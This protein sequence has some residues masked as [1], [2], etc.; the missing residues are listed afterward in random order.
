MA[1]KKK[2]YT[3]YKKEPPK[4]IEIR[5]MIKETKDEFET[6]REKRYVLVDADTGKVFDDAQGYGYKSKQSAMAKYSYASKSKE[7][8]HKIAK[9][10]ALV[11][12]FWRTHKGFGDYVSELA[13]DN[14]KCGQKFTAKDLE[15]AMSVYGISVP[16]GLSCAKLIKYW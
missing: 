9:E 3:G 16:D 15:E 8:L 13:L 7:E 10:K 4:N 1:K 14:T 5:E 6:Y 2:Q 12:N 11:Q